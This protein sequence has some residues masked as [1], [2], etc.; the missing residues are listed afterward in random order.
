MFLQPI[1]APSILGLFGF[2]A[3]TFMV[4]AHLA[5]WYGTSSSPEYLFPLAATFGGLAQ[6]A[7]AM[8]AYRARDAVA[9]AMHGTWGAFWLAYG[10]LYLFV[11][12]GDITVPAGKFP[13]LAF[14]LFP[15][16][17]IT[18]SGAVASVSENLGMTATLSS[19]AVGAG[20]L[21]VGYLVNG[22]GW[23]DAGGWV[24][25]ASAICAFYTASAMMLKASFG[26]VVLPLAEPNAE[27]NIP[28]R[29]FTHP[30]EYVHG[31]PGVK[32]GQ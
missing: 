22:S 23:L 16:A 24:L 29:V 2:A 21:G 12:A 7:A 19:L 3:A 25:I 27:A 26:R 32:Q 14:W 20:L 15:I 17:A 18:A 6:F 11:A 8:W 30:I 31:E 9:T 13:E 28:G 1:A 4:A 10:V 5:G